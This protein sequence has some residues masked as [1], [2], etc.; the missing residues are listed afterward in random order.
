MSTG[1]RWSGARP[2]RAPSVEANARLTGTT[3]VVLIGLLFAEGLTIVSIGTLLPWH[4]GIGLAL[5]PPVALKIGS[6]LW[7]FGRY[8]LRDPRYRQAGPPHP[9]LR[10]LGPVVVVS[11][12]L[13][14]ASGVATWLAGP[15]EHSLSALHKASFIVWFAVMALHVLAHVLRAGRLTRADLVRPRPGGQ[16]V[17]SARLRQAAVLASLVAGAVLGVAFRGLVSGWAVW[18]HAH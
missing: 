18:V 3:G 10:A 8:Y 9:L 2:R 16:P 6:T 5:V 7:R 14:L 17:S 11:T 1:L 13:V 12:V 4:V 15:S